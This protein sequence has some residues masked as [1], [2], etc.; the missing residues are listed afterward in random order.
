MRRAGMFWWEIGLAFKVSKT[1]IQVMLRRFG[2]EPTTL[3]VEME[4]D[5]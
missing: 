4:A 2:I 3:Q 1:Y 5:Q